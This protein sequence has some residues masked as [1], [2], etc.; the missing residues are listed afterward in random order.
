MVLESPAS[1]SRR[2][3]VRSR[4]LRSLKELPTRRPEPPAPHGSAVRWERV[5]IDRYVVLVHGTTVGFVDVVGAVFV[6]LSGPRYARAVEVLQTLDFAAAVDAV[7]L[8]DA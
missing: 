7:A 3:A 4:A 8:A 6:A 5:D 2:N 1:S